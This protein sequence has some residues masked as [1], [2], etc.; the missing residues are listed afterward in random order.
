MD[1]VAS[2]AG[3]TKPVLYQHFPNKRALFTTLL[4]DVGYQ[5]LTELGAIDTSGA[6]SS[7]RTF[8]ASITVNRPA[9]RRFDAMKCS[10]S[11]ASLVAD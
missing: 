2:A 11:N 5:L 10:T 8:V 6:R 1:D 7:A 3:V 9:A 4:E